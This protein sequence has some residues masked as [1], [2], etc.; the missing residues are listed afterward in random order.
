M[1]SDYDSDDDCIC[2]TD[3]AALGDCRVHTYYLSDLIEL[4][5]EDSSEEESEVEQEPEEVEQ[6]SEVEQEPEEVEQ[7]PEEVEQASEEVKQ[8][9][10]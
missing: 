4:F 2:G 6:E 3:A 7:E 10:Q 1:N 5:E 9:K 8:N